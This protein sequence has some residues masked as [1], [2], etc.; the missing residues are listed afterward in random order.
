MITAKGHNGTVEFDGDFVTISRTGALARLTVGKGAKRI[1]VGSISS[2]QMKPAGALV[3][4]F[5]SFSMAGGTERRS[6]FG[7]QTTDAVNDE[8]SVIITKK[9]MPEFEAL[10]AAVEQAVAD[11]S[12]PAA[13]AAPASDAMDQLAKLAELHRAGVVTDEEFAAKKAQLLGG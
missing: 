8:N 11:R 13:A 6:K 5:I 2:V 4:G 12:R 7:S 1:P 9:Q 10:R 3:N